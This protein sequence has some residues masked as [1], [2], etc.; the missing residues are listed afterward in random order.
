[1]GKINK[2]RN[3]EDE[4]KRNKANK[5]RKRKKE[6]TIQNDEEIRWNKERKKNNKLGRK[7]VMT[8]FFLPSLSVFFFFSSNLLK[9]KELMI[10]RDDEMK[11][12]G[13]K[14]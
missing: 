10:M 7:K 11:R 1:M 6:N 2:E 9:A 12:K 14:T 13:N 4:M 8:I 3:K 5:Q